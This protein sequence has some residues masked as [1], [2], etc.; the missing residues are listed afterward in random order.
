MVLV[1]GR[2][3]RAVPLAVGEEAAR[4]LN[5]PGPAVIDGAGHVPYAEQPRQFS[6]VLRRFLSEVVR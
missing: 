5:L 2:E 6:A 3:D 1:W 4:R